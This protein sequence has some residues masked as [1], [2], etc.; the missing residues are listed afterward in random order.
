[1]RLFNI[2]IIVVINYHYKS[3]TSTWLLQ[4]KNLSVGKTVEQNLPRPP[5]EICMW[6][7]IGHNI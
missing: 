1:M 3:N 6:T 2:F 7:E 4:N 5:S